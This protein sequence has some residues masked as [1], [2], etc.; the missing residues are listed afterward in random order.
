MKWDGG[1]LSITTNVIIMVIVRT[2]SNQNLMFS[3]TYTHVCCCEVN[4]TT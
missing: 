2:V 1:E 4:C 3:D